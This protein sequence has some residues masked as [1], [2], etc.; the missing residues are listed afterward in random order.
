MHN[1]AYIYDYIYIYIYIYMYIYTHKCKY[2]GTCLRGQ[3]VRVVAQIFI[4]LD[5]HLIALCLVSSHFLRGSHSRSKVRF[6]TPAGYICTSSVC[7]CIYIY[8]YNVSVCMYIY[9][10]TDIK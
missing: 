2:I 9:I 6:L 4:N 8:I 10:Y 5:M 3:T 7:E 1:N